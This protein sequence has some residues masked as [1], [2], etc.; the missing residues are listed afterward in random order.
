MKTLQILVTGMALFV[1]NTTGTEITT[2]EHQQLGKPGHHTHGKDNLCVSPSYVFLIHQILI[3]DTVHCPF[4]PSK[5]IFQAL[6]P[7][8]RNLQ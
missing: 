8:I 2:V 1:T 5:P 6:P 7:T 4:Y 3:Q